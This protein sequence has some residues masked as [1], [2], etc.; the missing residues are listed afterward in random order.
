MHHRVC[1]C[2]RVC[3]VGLILR[4]WEE[5]VLVVLVVLACAALLLAVRWGSWCAC[6][7]VCARLHLCLHGVWM[8]L[9][10]EQW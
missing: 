2:P 1:V 10:A 9:R 7:R 8:S 3:R 6:V 5:W 4:A